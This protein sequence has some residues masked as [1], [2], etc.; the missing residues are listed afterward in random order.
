L[1][2]DNS[3]ALLVEVLP[4]FCAELRDLLVKA[5]EPA[6]ADQIPNLNILDGCGCGDDF[7]SS[8]YTKPKP[9]GAYGPGHR[10]IVLEPERGMIILDVLGDEIAHVEVLNRN[11][12]RS[13]LTAALPTLLEPNS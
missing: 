2:E 10:T 6:L 1:K 7:C 4:S 8:F 11:D 3:N 12:I 5:S 13:A 9:C